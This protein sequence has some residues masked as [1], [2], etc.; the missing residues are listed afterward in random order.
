MQAQVWGP[1]VSLIGV[2][3]GS[4][5][6]YLAQV[7]T[8]RQTHRSEDD[9]QARELAETRRT[10]Q[11]DLLRQFIRIA[12]RAERT[13][14]D[15]QDGPAWHAAAK[16]VLDDLWISER[17]FHVLFGRTDLHAR[18]RAYVKALNDVIWE[19]PPGESLH[20]YL[21]DPKTAFL[22]A[23]HAELGRRQR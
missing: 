20:E 22:D 13:A 5:V 2:V 12:Q 7:T 23:A 11:L 15:R 14:E 17:M 1:V 16:D 8:Q 4:G 9:R 10:E 21:R 18:A 19:D 6:S 3:L